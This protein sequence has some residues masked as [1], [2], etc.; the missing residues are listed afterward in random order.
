MAGTDGFAPGMQSPDSFRFAGISA[1][2]TQKEHYQH[3]GSITLEE[4]YQG[5]WQYHQ[6]PDGLFPEFNDTGGL[7]RFLR[8]HDYVMWPDDGC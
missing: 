5:L 8:E 3:G 7:I 2:L 1:I 4:S 6:D